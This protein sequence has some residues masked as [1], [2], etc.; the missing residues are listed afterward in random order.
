MTNQE[1][2]RRVG[3]DPQIVRTIVR[4]KKNWIGRILRVGSL[5]KD[6]IEGRMDGKRPRE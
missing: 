1:V 4:R 2:L 6:I 3:E 5:L